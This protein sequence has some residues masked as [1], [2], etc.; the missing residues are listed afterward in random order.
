MT[1]QN[2]LLRAV[3]QLPY[4]H[5]GLYAPVLTKR[6]THMLWEIFFSK[7]TATFP[8]LCWQHSAQEA[9]PSKHCQARANLFLSRGD[10]AS[11]LQNLSTQFAKFPLVSHYQANPMLQIPHGFCGCGAPQTNPCFASVPFSLEPRQAAE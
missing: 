7:R 3:I 1:R 6:N 9:W 8:H 11:E 2:Q 5:H 10:S 4:M